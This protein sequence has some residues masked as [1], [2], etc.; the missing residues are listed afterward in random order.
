MDDSTNHLD[1]KQIKA[2]GILLPVVLSS[3]LVQL[4]KFLET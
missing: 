3:L 2:V 1:L 4:F